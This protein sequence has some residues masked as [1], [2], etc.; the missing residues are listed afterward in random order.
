MDG[1]IRAIIP[2]PIDRISISKP[3]FLSL[4]PPPN[5]FPIVHLD[6]IITITTTPS[7]TP[8]TISPNLHRALRSR[9]VSLF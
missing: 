7:P 5:S 2:R 1:S 6:T 4:H 3:P 9:P 8:L